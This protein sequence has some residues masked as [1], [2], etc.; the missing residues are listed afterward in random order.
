MDA[1]ADFIDLERYPIDNLE[2]CAG[3]TLIESCQAMMR[4]RAICALKGFLR[5][6]FLQ[7]ISDEVTQLESEMR[8]VDF[9]A[10]PYGWLKN[11]GFS[12]THPRSR[13]FDRRC[14][15]LTRDQLDSKGLC[16][17]LFQF[18]ELTEFVRQLLGYEQLFNSACPNI[19]VRLNIM[20]P[21]DEFG[22]HYDTNDGA[23]SLVLQSAEE[24]G[25][26]EYAPLIRNEADENYDRVG[27][28]F[29]G[30]ETPDVADAPAG[31]FILFMGRRSLHRVAPI[32]KSRRS[33]QTLL[34]SYDRQPGM[35]FPEKIRKRMLEPSG[36][37]FLGQ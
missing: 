34:F 29:S 13:V 4:E 24:G 19:S 6:V 22:W 8:R 25:D 23:V 36:E 12:K 28:I 37:P 27:A 16:V 7:E 31:T 33:R 30:E 9:P 26:F 3:R 18:P 21:G 20:E 14:G 32:G 10:T 15:V 17:R 35:V 2:S 1:L 11:T 5:P